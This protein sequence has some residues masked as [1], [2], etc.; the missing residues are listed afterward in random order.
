M[1]DK[2]PHWTQTERGKEILAARKGKGKR[3][4][5]IVEGSSLERIPDGKFAYAHGYVDAFI[6]FYAKGQGLSARSLAGELGAV[7]HRAAR[8]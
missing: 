5:A 6:D 3:K 4:H 7:L 2:K 1:A 8:R